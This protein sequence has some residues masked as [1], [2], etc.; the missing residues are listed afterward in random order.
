[1]QSNDMQSTIIIM[2]ESTADGWNE[3]FLSMVPYTVV[4]LR[5][6]VC[7]GRTYWTALSSCIR[8]LCQE[9]RVKR[10]PPTVIT[11]IV[12]FESAFIRISTIHSTVLPWRTW[13]DRLGSVESTR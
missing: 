11:T 3:P 13:V 7:S 2:M 4:S 10:V 6:R 1:V 8:T 5:R 9:S 12:E